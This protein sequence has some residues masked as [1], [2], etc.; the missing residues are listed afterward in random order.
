MS[1]TRSDNESA[2]STLCKACGLCCTGHMFINAEFTPPEVETTRALGL[3]VLQADP[4]KPVFQLP[5]PLWQGHCTIYNHPHK[6]SICGNYKCKLLKEVEGGQLD[7][8]AALI[9]VEQAKG[10]IRELEP[11]LPASQDTNFR[12]RLFEYAKRLEAA[13]AQNNGENDFRLKTGALLVMFA[14]RFGVTGLFNKP[15]AEG[16]QND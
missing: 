10:L 7:L 16:P 14:K 6:P 4:E 5:C 3:S 13:V 12:K 2:S 9:V 1:E 11:H 15:G 8:S